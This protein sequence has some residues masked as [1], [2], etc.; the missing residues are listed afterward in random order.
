MKTF[1]APDKNYLLPELLAH[2]FLVDEVGMVFHPTL[3]DVFAGR[4][5]QD[6]FYRAMRKAMADGKGYYGDIS[7]NGEN[8]IFYPWADPG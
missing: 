3:D 1:N 2:G 8:V 4:Q 5:Y 6:A 7:R